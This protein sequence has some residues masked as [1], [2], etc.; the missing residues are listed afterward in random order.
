VPTRQLAAPVVASYPA[1]ILVSPA[2][3]ANASGQTT[4]SWSWDGPALAAN[5]AFE[6]RI[7]QEGQPDHYGAA[8]PV[9]TTSVTIDVRT[10]YG[11]TQGGS[12]TYYWTVALVERDPYKR[13]GP[14]ASPRTLAVSV[15]ASR[16]QPTLAPP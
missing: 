9:R 10:A 3:R 13:I 14:E 15:G 2:D 12:G 11:V 4:F 7:W 16:P 6:I 5:Q 1:P 8:E